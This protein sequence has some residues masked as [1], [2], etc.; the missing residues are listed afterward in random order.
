MV[1]F[2]CSDQLVLAAVNEVFSILVFAKESG[3]LLRELKY[4]TLDIQIVACHPANDKIIMSASYDGSVAVWNVES[5]RR[6]FG[7]RTNCKFLDGA[8]S[9]SGDYFA[10]TDDLGRISLF[11]YG[12]SADTYS[13]A[14]DVQLLFSDWMDAVFDE[15]RVPI[16]PIAQRPSHMIPPRLTYGLERNPNAIA[17]RESFYQTAFESKEPWLGSEAQKKQEGLL[18][19]LPSGN[20]S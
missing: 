6:L 10:L 5:G 1:S 16:D 13:L 20:C 15:N 8:F 11:A 3:E 14:P 17:T 4:H 12:V 7:H 18:R 9:P 19:Q 2:A